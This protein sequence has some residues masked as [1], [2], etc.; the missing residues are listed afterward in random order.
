ML[1]LEQIGWR[2]RN[3]ME[4]CDFFVCCWCRSN[5]SPGSGG[6]YI[7]SKTLNNHYYC[8]NCYPKAVEVFLADKK[9]KEAQA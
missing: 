4:C 2:Q 1:G 6:G 8:F 9:L 3:S 5:C 7:L